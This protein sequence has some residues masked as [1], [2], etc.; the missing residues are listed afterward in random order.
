MSV[1]NLIKTAISS[2]KSHKLRS[3][4]TMIGIIIGISSV[5]TI[6]SIGNGLKR[7]VVQSS[8]DTSANK[9]NIYFQPD[10]MGAD[11][12]LIEPFTK[13]DLNSITRI[14]GVQKVEAAQGSLAGMSFVLS[15]ISY[16]DKQTM[17]ILDTYEKK[18]L[19]ILHG[20]IM[21]EA[22]DNRRLIVLDYNTAVTMFENPEE[23]LGKGVNLNGTYYEVIG[24]L[25]EAGMFSLTGSYSYISEESKE[26]M[27]T[28][29]I[30]SSIDV[31]INPDVDK[32]AVFEEVVAELEK[33]HPNIQGEYELQDPQAITKVFEKIIGGLTAFIAI[34][35]G[36]SLFVGGIG[37]M[38]IMYVSVSERKREIGI[39]RAIGA[40]PKSILLQFL[41]EAIFI[42][43][44]GG[45]LGILFGYL[46][47]QIVGIFVPFAPVLTIGSF[48]GST[49]TSVI[50]GVVFGIIPASKASKM[51]PIKAIYL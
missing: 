24:V 31:Y 8:E 18:S 32:E 20:R 49:L 15:D 11:Y 16:F 22:E 7:E 5:V 10:N 37:V 40:K 36:I 25:A 4:L 9:I 21:N 29:E 48:I 28:A 26:S 47:S 13:S 3:F 6:L 44:I 14:E 42:T 33:N 41:F 27:G 30:I 38:N 34:I 19:N 46:F 23:A 2:L 43:G 39:R 51:D 50:V 35:T 45:L 17:I 1:A 12:S